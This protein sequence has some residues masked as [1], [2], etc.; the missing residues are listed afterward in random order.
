MYLEQ[1]AHIIC[2]KMLNIIKSIYYQVRKYEYY[3]LK[4]TKKGKP[5]YSN[6][7]ARKVLEEI[8]PKPDGTIQA[9]NVTT[10]EIDLSIIVPAYNVEQFIDQ[11]IE[12]ILEQQTKYAY[13]IIIIND[14]S[15]DKTEQKLKKYE[16]DKR[17]VLIN[18]KNGGFSAA[19]NAGLKFFRGKYV[20]FVD[21]DDYIIPG[22]IEALM[23]CAYKHNADI[24]EG[25]AFS[26]NDNDRKELF[27]H[28]E[29]KELDSGLGVLHGYPWAK[30][31]RSHLFQNIKY[32]VGFWY[33]DTLIGMIVYQMKL[34]FYTIPDFV[35]CYRINPN[36]ITSTSMGKPRSIES[37][38][39]TEMLLQEQY[40]RGISSE[41]T[42]DSYIGQIAMNYHRTL[43][44]GDEVREAIFVLS[45]EAYDKYFRGM[46]YNGQDYRKKE[47]FRC[48][49]ENDWKAGDHLLK[50]W[51][52]L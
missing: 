42:L 6:E 4:T 18:Q 46:K 2:S 12:S 30:V 43:G 22:T 35:Y 31:Y 37:Y 27:K 5:S 34:K 14:G 9:D 25:S 33:E 24:V 45:K 15:T 17:V 36:G 48:I 44:L 51:G 32:P 47:L 50:Y 7:E 26:F 40:D 52:Y 29:V 39:I 19:R 1:F 21:S 3:V 16:A 23:S 8:C 49:K 41:K 38:W 20:M 13:E 28:A 10:N 11:C